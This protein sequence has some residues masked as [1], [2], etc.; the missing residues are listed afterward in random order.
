MVKQP[1]IFF[2]PL[3]IDWPSVW[4]DSQLEGH[5]QSTLW[6][7]R[8]VAAVW[9]DVSHISYLLW[10]PHNQK[11]MT[12]P[13]PAYWLDPAPTCDLYIFFKLLQCFESLEKMLFHDTESSE[14]SS[15]YSCKVQ[16]LIWFLNHMNLKLLKLIVN[17]EKFVGP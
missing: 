17:C 15:V 12:I 14:G 1:L 7:N 5:K 8:I 2:G 13:L 3:D 4:S 11:N 6:K 10:G 9:S 16:S